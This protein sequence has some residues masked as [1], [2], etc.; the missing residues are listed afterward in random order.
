MKYLFSFLCVSSLLLPLIASDQIPGAPQ[1]DAIALTGVTLHPVSG[2]VIENATI[3]FENGKITALG[4]NLGMPKQGQVIRLDGMH[5]YPGL[6]ESVSQLGLNEVGAVRSTRDASEVGDFNPNVKS[7]VAINPDSEHF[8]VT[9]ANGVALAGVLPGGGMISGLAAVVMNDGWTYEDMTLKAPAGLVVDWPN[10][11]VRRAPWI[12]QS[13]K[14]Q[15]K[16]IQENLLK[17][18][19]MFS[20][21]RAYHL[22]RTTNQNAA[23]FDSRFEAMR[24]V[25]D[26]SLPV[27]INAEAAIEIR[28][29]IDFSQKHQFNMVLVGGYDAPKVTDLLKRY[30]IPVVLVKTQQLPF[31]RHEAYDSPFTAP[32][33]LYDAGV[34]FAISANEFAG[35][36]RNL[37]YHA[38]TAAAFGLPKD[39]ALRAITLDA[40]KIL[41]V[42]DRVG[43]L[44]VGKDATLI[45]TDGD[46]LEVT[47]QTLHMFI[48]GRKVDLTSRQTL[49]YHK[50]QKKYQQLEGK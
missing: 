19:D 13:P 33:A 46:P 14:E 1:K 16:A 48:Q 8:P 30:D 15:E 42:G 35:N 39:V 10:M 20:Q 23:D 11:T 12:R 7:W 5:V 38:A 41:G 31:R 2:A 49:L 3:L 24:P 29:A 40:A 37:P 43:S 27:W 9:R 25:F 21:A 22:G 36:N 26:G 44:E 4:A 18:D 28:A 47:T 45:V 32:K 34:R 17:L 6:I 50:Y